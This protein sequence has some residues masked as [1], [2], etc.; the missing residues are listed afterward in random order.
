MQA[1]TLCF[2]SIVRPL[3]RSRCLSSQAYQTKLRTITWND[4]SQAL[5]PFY[6]IVHPDLFWK[7]P[8]EKQKN[9]D[10]L[11]QLNAYLEGLIKAPST[12][13][14]VLNVN[15]YLREPDRAKDPDAPFRN[16]R[17][18]LSSADPHSSVYEVLKMCGLSTEGLAPPKE[19]PAENQL[20]KDVEDMGEDAS[21]YN[22]RARGDFSWIVMEQQMQREED[23][24]L[25]Q[26]LESNVQNAHELRLKSAPLHSEARR[27][28][29]DL[30]ASLSLSGLRWEGGWGAAHHRGCLESFRLLVEQYP[31]AAQAVRGR[32]V[33]FGRTT[34]ITLDGHVAL[35]MEDVRHNWLSFLRSAHRYTRY[36]ACVPQAE[37]DLSL[38]LRGICVDHRRFK[39]AVTAEKYIQQLS[40]LTTALH[41]YKWEHGGSFTNLPRDLSSYKL[42]VECEAGP[43]MLS[44]T[45]QFLTPASCPP[46]ILLK[47]LLDN[48][49][50]AT[51][52][53]ARHVGFRRAEVGLLDRCRWK[54]GLSGLS[55]DDS[56]T[57]EL[58]VQ[59]CGRLLA[60]A[61][62][63]WPLLQGC[64][65]H[66]SHYYSVLQDGIVCIP[67]DWKN[68]KSST[69]DQP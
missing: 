4:V 67:W 13:T 59:C 39:P 31:E 14:R 26:F 69:E 20:R 47:F 2:C 40:K 8:R 60:D 19:A 44:P 56:V 10:S 27:L 34:G 58:V 9:E 41:R 22:R 28:A 7:H 50:E 48:I 66:V 55:R 29:E 38:A 18:R 54:L 68:E 51:Q 6:F 17:I 43:L 30:M 15:F 64:H 45:G 62:R 37:R 25:E 65:L 53:R 61:D 52:R 35:S 36:V 32:A 16:V 1:M 46:R 49:E 42:G 24:Y 23:L 12:S 63:W 3:F 33:V 57:P 5:R 21:K 11:K